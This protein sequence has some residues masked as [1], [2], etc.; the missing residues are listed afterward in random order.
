MK[1]GMLEQKLSKTVWAQQGLKWVD[2]I[3]TS[4]NIVILCRTTL[5]QHLKQTIKI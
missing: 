5:K 4:P 3:Q 2:A 1:S